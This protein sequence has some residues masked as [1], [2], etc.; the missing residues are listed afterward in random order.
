MS[1]LLQRVSVNVQR[2]CAAPGGS[3][4]PLR[5]TSQVP[6]RGTRVAF[7]TGMMCQRMPAGRVAGR[8]DDS[9][10]DELHRTCAVHLELP[11]RFAPARMAAKAFGA[12]FLSLPAPRLPNR[13]SESRARAI[14]ASLTIH[15]LAVLLAIVLGNARRTPPSMADKDERAESVRLVFFAQPGPPAG[16][17]GGGAR[18]RAPASRASNA[19]RDRITRPVAP[20]ILA[21]PLS[22]ER[23]LPTQQVTIPAVPLADGLHSQI[24]A[25]QGLP[26]AVPSQGPGSGGG[27]GGGVGSGIGGGLGSGVGPG[28]G[29]GAGGGAYRLGDGVSPPIVLRQVRPSYT[30]E[31]VRNRIQGSVLLE[32]VVLR[33][34]HVGEARVVRSLD[35]GL[36]LQAIEAVRAWQFLPGRRG[37]IAVDVLVSIVMD[38]AIR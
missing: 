25:L 28:S 2:K 9:Q 16:G 29:G 26:S 7:E 14:T 24:G 23:P 31:A 4:T 3:S 34:G 6:S 15:T 36:D 30:P 33:T 35:R 10:G 32:V 20:P 13:R 27:A 18:N 11:A 19:G 17:G 37:D 5:D 1:F 8:P 21:Q 22:S 38:F 12:P